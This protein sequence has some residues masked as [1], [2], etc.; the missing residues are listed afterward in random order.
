MLITVLIDGD[1]ALFSDL[2]P[3]GIMAVGKIGEICGF[4][5]AGQKIAGIF[6]WERAEF[7]PPRVPRHNCWL[8]FFAECRCQR[9]THGA[10]TRRGVVAAARFAL[11][12]RSPVGVVPGR[13]GI[14][15]AAG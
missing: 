6:Y 9:I 7:I 4:I 2:K 12:G 15:A 8:G 3:R 10:V 5:E 11:I 14:T 1:V 13:G